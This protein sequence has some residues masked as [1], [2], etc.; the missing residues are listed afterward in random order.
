MFGLDIFEWVT[1]WFWDTFDEIFITIFDQILYSLIGFLY[2]CFIIL[3][4]MDIFGG[5]GDGNASAMEMYQAFTTRIYSVLGVIMIFVLAYQI[6]L[7]IIDPDKGMKDSQKIVK[8]LVKGII[9]VIICPLV[10]HYMAIFQQHILNDN[11]IWAVVLGS[12]A[13]SNDDAISAGNSMAG[14]VYMTMF[15]PANTTYT[16]FY[17]ADGMLNDYDDACKGY[18]DLYETLD[19]DGSKEMKYMSD[20]SISRAAKWGLTGTLVAGSVGG[21]VGIVVGGVVDIAKGIWDWLTGQ[22]DPKYTSC[23]MYWIQLYKADGG[24]IPDGDPTDMSK[25]SMS[26]LKKIGS[27]NAASLLSS[28]VA[29]ADEVRDEGT[30]EYFYLSPIVGIILVWMLVAYSLDMA[31]RAFKLAFLE[32]IAPIPILIGVIPKQEELFKK[33]LNLITKTYIDVFVRTFVMAFAVFMIQLVPVFVDALFSAFTDI[34]D[35]AALLK[36]AVIIFL[37]IGLLRFARE[38]PG[39]IKDLASSGSKLFEDINP[40]NSYKKSKEALKPIGAVAGAA[41]GGASAFRNTAK[42]IPKVHSANYKDLNPLQKGLDNIVHLKDNAGRYLEMAGALRKGAVVGGKQGYKDGFGI[43][44]ATSAMTAA[45]GAAEA[46]HNK[47][48]SLKSHLFG[49]NGFHGLQALDEL[50]GGK[51]KKF[52]S[53]WQGDLDNIQRTENLKAATAF[54]SVGKAGKSLI[55]SKSGD[56]KNELAAQRATAL[57]EV[58]KATSA[59]QVWNS[60]AKYEA[61]L[62]EAMK[63]PYS[64]QGDLVYEYNGRQYIA[65]DTTQIA[66]VREQI[67]TDMMNQLQK[68]VDSGSAG[69]FVTKFRGEEIVG[70]SFEDVERK[71]RE[72]TNTIQK[73]YDL[74]QYEDI[75]KG[76]DG[77]KIVQALAKNQSKTMVEHGDVLSDSQR[78]ALTNSVKNVFAYD[79]DSKTYKNQALIDALGLQTADLGNLNTVMSKL[80]GIKFTETYNGLSETEQEAVNKGIADL[81]NSVSTA[82]TKL[83]NSGRML[84]DAMAG[85][86]TNAMTGRMEDS[87]APGPGPKPEGGGDSGKGGK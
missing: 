64:D 84:Q 65:S 42:R 38:L 61:A 70:T 3:G 7:F 77:L 74:Q 73:A 60:D 22:E 57:N 78:E 24:T 56:K 43:K 8:N 29:L 52:S 66:N 20:D 63:N 62:N 55:A 2:K 86:R 47:M 81:L 25:Y 85:A 50:T 87:L 49:E 54:D 36:A 83:A 6:I 45:N 4:S 17:D 35:G 10:F 67:K 28:N 44:S 68:Q 51:I 32:M 75:I 72:K 16:D 41:L 53:A 30:M 18:E 79:E 34:V 48:T 82:E 69:A 26:G 9:L 14:M 58:G 11:T 59:Q 27:V 21:L 12:S 71:I 39:M 15:H 46:S 13:T 31:Y 19:P 76:Q 80:G 1:N 40:M 33:W 23:Q 5:G 37:V